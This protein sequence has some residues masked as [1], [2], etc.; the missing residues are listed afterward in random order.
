MGEALA[1][2]IG[3]GAMDGVVERGVVGEGL[4]GE[5]MRLRSRHTGSMSLSS[6]AYFG[7]HSTVSQCARAA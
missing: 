1:V 3:D 2:E 5:M 6:G 4:V 7:S